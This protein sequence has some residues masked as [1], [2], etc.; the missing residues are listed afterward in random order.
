MPYKDPEI[1]RLCKREWYLSNKK[2]L[3]QRNLE[4][5]ARNPEK[6]KECLRTWVEKNPERSRALKLKWYQK[7]K[8]L[9]RARGRIRDAI[10][11]ATPAGRLRLAFAQSLRKALKDKKDGRRWESFVDYSLS[12]LMA[13]LEA[14][15]DSNMTWENYGSYWWVDHIKPMALFNFEIL[16]EFKECW[17][18]N[19]LQPLEKIANIK[20][21]NKYP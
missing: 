20:K 16:E 10:R 9:V 5:R 12:E 13:H 18:L 7:N 19:N 2:A 21:G 11:R 1:N 8:E 6:Y 15:F 17:T 4:W 14:K 3:Y